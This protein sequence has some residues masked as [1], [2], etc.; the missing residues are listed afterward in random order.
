MKTGLILIYNLG[1]LPLVVGAIWVRLT[2][3]RNKSLGFTFAAGFATVLAAFLCMTLPMIHAGSSVGDIAHRWRV[4]SLVLGLVST[5]VCVK[6]L[7]E[8]L[9]DWIKERRAYDLKQW[10]LVLLTL[11]TIILSVFF[12]IPTAED[13]TLPIIQTNRA[14]ATI[15][16]YNPY[17]G[18]AYGQ[19]LAEK[20]NSPLEVYYDVLAT[21]AGIEPLMLLRRILPVFLLV[22]FFGVVDYLSCVLFPEDGK[23]NRK[24]ERDDF[25]LAIIVIYLAITPIY[26]LGSIQL[27]RNSWLDKTFFMNILI[28][29]ALALIIDYLR[30]HNNKGR[31]GLIFLMIIVGFASQ[32]TVQMG[33]IWSM[34]LILPGFIIGTVSSLVNGKKMERRAED[35]LSR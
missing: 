28:P 29:F 7:F 25:K 3:K 11:I 1:L 4:A 20:A 33:F 15:Y 5:L 34:T 8:L 6:T 30:P 35:G 10:G 2:A 18:E 9:A 16:E 22:F 19:I 13:Y 31:I 12:T 24:K 23:G 21:W 17:T 32:L 14:T 27:L 26:R